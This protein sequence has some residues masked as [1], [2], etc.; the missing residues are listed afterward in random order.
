MPVN[1]VTQNFSVNNFFCRCAFVH[2]FYNLIYL[3]AAVLYLIDYLSYGNSHQILK[4]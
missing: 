2:A 1:Y 4:D 3:L